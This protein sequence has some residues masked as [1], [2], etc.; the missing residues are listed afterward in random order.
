MDF[1]IWRYQEERWKDLTEKAQERRGE[2]KG[3]QAS[4]C[5]VEVR[6]R[7]DSAEWS[8]M[9]QFRVIGGEKKKEKETKAGDIN[10]ERQGT[11][12]QKECRAFGHHRDVGYYWVRRKIIEK[13][14][15]TD[16]HDLS[17]HYNRITLTAILR[18]GQKQQMKKL[19]DQLEAIAMT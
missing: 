14:W 6:A 11:G 5:Q 3:S 9:L 2:V 8:G 18:I 13:F 12:N 4:A 7:K 1:V 16:W 10:L 19:G 17:Q 15:A